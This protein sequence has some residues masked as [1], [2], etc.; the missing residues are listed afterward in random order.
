MIRLACIVSVIFS[1]IVCAERPGWKSKRIHSTFYS[2]GGSVGDIDGD[3]HLDVV[4]GP[5]WVKGPDFEQTTAFAP[6]TEFNP[7]GYGDQF[8]SKVFDAN[9]DDQND[10]LVLGFPGKEARLYI[11]PGPVEVR[12]HWTMHIITGAVDNESPHIVDFIP[13]GLPEIVCGNAGQFG[14]YQASDD[15][16]KPWTWTPIA[17]KGSCP[18]KFTHGMGVGDVNGDGR[19]DILGKTYWWEHPVN[20]TVD[21]QV[22]NRQY[23]KKRQWALEGYGGGGAQIC[24]DDVDGDGDNDIVTSYNAHAYGLGWFEQVSIERFVRHDIMG[25]SST[26]NPYGVAFSQLHALA[27]ADI[28]GDGRKDIVTGKRFMAHNFK[29]PGGKQEPVLY[30]FKNTPVDSRAS[31]NGG[32]DGRGPQQSSNA[33]QTGRLEDRPSE[34]EFVPHLIDNNSGVGVDTTVADLNGDGKL[35]I[36]TASKIGLILHT[37]DPSVAALPAEKWRVVEGRDQ[38]KYTNGFEAEDAAKNMLV[39][40][41]F[42]VDLIASEPELTQPI[43]MCFDAKGRLWVIEGHTYPQ[44]APDGQGRDRI[45]VLEDNDA[46]GS[47]ETKKTF[48]DDVNLASGIEVGFGGVWVGA[49]P[50]LLFYPDADHDCVPDGEPQILLDGWHWEDTHE[51][52]NSFTWGPDGWLYG[53]HGVFTHSV[54]GKPGTPEDQRQKIN[55]GVWRYHP[56]RHEFEIYAHG[57]SNPWG[58]DY[59]QNGEW[60]VEAC[61]IPHLFHIV[62]GGRYFR[63]AGQHFNKSTYDDIKTIADHAHYTGGTFDVRKVMGTTKGGVLGTSL[64]G[65]GHA[66]CGF[67][68]YNGDAF[69]RAVSRRSV[70]PQPARPPP[71]PRTPGT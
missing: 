70:L 17:E 54:V 16:T 25:A 28:D 48:V 4:A 58:L 34:I 49:A 33:A 21:Q 61:V 10:V 64:L 24:V 47:F 53:C 65:G 23:W 8:F 30:W 69:P 3:G 32:S 40:E 26:D 59:D 9:G 60:F 18:H 50:Y 20:A 55:A 68:F 14:F 19:L 71:C 22:G 6:L 43:A 15:A 29:D 56:T 5:L 31:A 11:N 1:S 52:L 51:T 37:Q 66:H 38:G 67:A 39:P 12:E 2:E 45:V 41:G 42:H 7:A 62:Q 46:D 44:R 36:V 13:G 63:Q 27:L 35:D 57:T